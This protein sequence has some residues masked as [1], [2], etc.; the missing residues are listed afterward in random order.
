MYSGFF[1]PFFRFAEVPGPPKPLLAL[2]CTCGID[3]GSWPH[4]TTKAHLTVIAARLCMCTG[5]K[6]TTMGRTAAMPPRQHTRSV[7]QLAGCNTTA[8]SM[9]ASK[10]MSTLFILVCVFI[11]CTN[12][13]EQRAA[14][15]CLL[16][17]HAFWLNSVFGP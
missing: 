12:M 2:A 10:G 13:F 1:L 14:A 9:Q 3:L 16:A 8:I 5:R 17:G 11:T 4:G 15:W 6:L 7:A